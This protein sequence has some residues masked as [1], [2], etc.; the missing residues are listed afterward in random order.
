MAV[1]TLRCTFWFA[2]VSG[3]HKAGFESA[4]RAGRCDGVQDV[5]ELFRYSSACPESLH[6]VCDRGAVPP[7]ATL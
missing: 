4:G 6:A 2:T 3:D 7:S 5:V 1:V